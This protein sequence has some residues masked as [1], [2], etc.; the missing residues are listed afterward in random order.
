[1]DAGTKMHLRWIRL[2]CT[3]HA[4]PMLPVFKD[5]GILFVPIKA[6]LVWFRYQG[7]LMS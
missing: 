2:T 7:I 3:D 6:I 1:M 5:E 4:E